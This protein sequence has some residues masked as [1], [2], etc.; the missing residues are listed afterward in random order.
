M[1]IHPEMLREL[2]MERQRDLIAEADAYRVLSSA[3]RR[4]RSRRAR[5]S[6]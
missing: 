6:D 4:R 3:R 5:R 2:A 1:F